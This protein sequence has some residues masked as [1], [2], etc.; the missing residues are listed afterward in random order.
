[1]TSLNIH[2]LAPWGEGVLRTGEG[3]VVWQEV[4]RSRE[5]YV[6][7]QL[8][9]QPSPIGEEVNIGGQSGVQDEID[10]HPELVSGSHKILKH[11][12]QSSVYKMLK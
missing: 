5:Q 9:P 6:E 10:C 4:L 7:N 3:F 12:G 1:M 2:T 8:S 11:R